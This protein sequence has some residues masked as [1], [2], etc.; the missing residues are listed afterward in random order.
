MAERILATL[1]KEIAKEHRWNIVG[2]SG[3]WIF[4]IEVNPE[5]EAAYVFGYDFPI[6]NTCARQLA[7]DKA[8]TADILHYTGIPCVD[9]R[10]FLPPSMNKYVSTSG[11]W[12]DMIAYAESHNWNMVIKP[13]IGTGGNRVERVRTPKELE[14]FASDFFSSEC[15]LCLSPYENII[16][17]CRVVMLDG[18]ALLAYEKIRPSTVG[19]GISSVGELL[20]R[21]ELA[22]V[23][24]ELPTG[25]DVT[26][27]PE[28][29]EIVYFNWRHNLGQGSRAKE[30]EKEDAEHWIVFSRKAMQALGLRFASVDSIETAEGIK[31]M[32]INAGVMMETYARQSPEAREKA[33][34]IYEKALEKVFASARNCAGL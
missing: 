28:K 32:E 25:K 6:N 19:D 3:D 14:L 24:S 8:G 4:R 17:E 7:K 13:N 31:I 34:M 1:L 27:I 23:L 26:R 20:L 5:G 9:H 10:L 29:N 22:R 2:F 12:K 21:S 33:K 15:A 11:S 18:K 30:L 16:R